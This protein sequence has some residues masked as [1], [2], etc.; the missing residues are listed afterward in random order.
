MILEIVGRGVRM[1]KVH[2]TFTCEIHSQG[3]QTMLGG[4]MNMNRMGK[5]LQDMQKRIAK[6]EEDLNSSSTVAP[7]FLT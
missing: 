3:D 1:A 2:P 7:R 4:G 5:Q 6:V